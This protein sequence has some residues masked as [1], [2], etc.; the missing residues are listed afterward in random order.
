M[1]SSKRN[2]EGNE[3]TS[4]EYKFHLDG[5]IFI[6]VSVF[7]NNV[8]TFDITEQD[9][10]IEWR[11]LSPRFRQCCKHFGGKREGYTN[12][13]KY[14]SETIIKKWSYGQAEEQG[15]YQLH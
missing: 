15:R 4:T 1:N 6:V 7:I 8:Y 14:F 10:S 5:D 12:A 13:W 2:I 9:I 3:K 11:V